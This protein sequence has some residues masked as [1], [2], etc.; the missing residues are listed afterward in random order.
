M[1]NLQQYLPHLAAIILFIVITF[2][3]FSPVLEGKA[4]RQGDIIHHK[5]MS[6]E[7]VDFR[8]EFHQEPLWT[9]SMFGGMPSYLI[10]TLYP[11]NLIRYIDRIISFGL[12]IPAKFLF[13]TLLGFYFLLVVGFRLNPWLGIAGAIAFSFSS[14]FFI[15]EVA[16][17]NSKAHAIVYIA[18][19]LTGIILCFRSKILWGGVITGIF[20]ALQIAA[21][22]PQITYYTLFIILIFGLVHLIKAFKER[23]LPLFFKI[24]GVLVIAVVLAVCVN[25]GYLWPVYEYGKDSI[26][27]KSE[28]SSNQENRT[29]GLDK[30]YIL[31]DYSY[32]IDE[33]FN[34]VIP[35]FKGG[36]SSGFDLNSKTYEELRRNN[37]PNAKQLVQSLPLAYWG[38]QRSTA[39]PVYIGA[40]IFF[41]FIMGLFIIKGPYKWWLALAVV[42]SIILAWGKNMMP[43]SD[44]FIRFFPGYNK[45]RTVSMILVI[46]EFAV[47]L[48]GILAVHKILENKL[49]KEEVLKALKYGFYI[50]GGV[51]LFFSVFP[52]LFFSFS[53]TIDNQ[54]SS[55]GWPSQFIQ[56]IQDDRKH[57]LQTDAFRSFVFIVLTG[58]VLLAYVFGKIKKSYLVLGLGIL[59]LADMWPVNK[60]YL[61]NNNFISKREVKE[62]FKPTS[63]DLAILQDHDPNFRVLNLTVDTFNE[64]STSYFHKSI[65]GYHGAKMR[66][67]QELITH[68]ISRNN[69][70]VLNMLNT[71]Y[72][73]VPGYDNQPVAQRNT[74]TLGNAWFVKSFKIVDN[75]D[76]EIE[77]LSDFDAGEE[78]IID[79]RFESLVGDFKYTSDSTAQVELTSYQPNHLIYKSVSDHDELAV[80]SE[81]YYDKGWEAYIDGEPVPYFRVN[82]VLRGMKVPAGAHKI[83][84][85]FRPK[86]YFTGEKISLFSSLLL[87]LLFAGLSF[88]EFKKWFFNLRSEEKDLKTELQN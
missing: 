42:I 53:A 88:V 24:A 28:L 81:I 30:A 67:Y 41:L 6:K 76:V 68:Q 59:F 85:I 61:N 83:E 57:L 23:S 66:R 11:S 40:V 12:R 25:I 18:P 71:K 29:S 48:L 72:I 21:G 77:A 62:P 64:A 58:S 45:F 47:P 52:G 17:H 1:K 20:L 22:H 51:T 84:F 7:I 4:L 3:Y 5:G 16:G 65:G 33:T 87:L 79:K 49:K 39:G 37:V 78:V 13:L 34:L 46:A 50:L 75:A 60:R 55:S 63:A 32:G 36:A 14:Y 35:N 43:V 38:N 73:I 69:M 19:I 31:N 82:Y 74:N 8:E 10:S 27:G 44:L 70:Q 54:L 56:A 2:T 86:A 26:R 15:I 9:N 80:F